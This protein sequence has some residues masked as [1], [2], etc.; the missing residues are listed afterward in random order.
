MTGVQTCALPISWKKGSV[1]ADT[2]Y[3]LTDEAGRRIPVQSF[4]SA[5]WP[6]GSVKWSRHSAKIERN[7][8][9]LFLCTTE[10]TEIEQSLAKELPDQFVIEG[11]RVHACVP[12]TGSLILKDLCTDGRVTAESGRLTLLL[13][14]REEE[15]GCVVTKQVPYLGV[16]KEA[17]LEE[18][19]SEKA[20]IC[21]HGVHRAEQGE[22]KNIREIL[23]FVLRLTFY[24]ESENIHITHTFLYDG[25]EQRDFLKGLGI[26]FQ[27]PL[28]GEVYN[29]HV[30][31]ASEYG[32]FHESMK[33]LLAWRPRIPLDLYERQMAG[34]NLDLDQMEEQLAKDIRQAFDNMPTWSN[35]HICQDSA[36]HYAIR[37]RTGYEKCCYLDCQHG[38]RAA[39]CAAVAGEDGGIA[40][41]LRDFWQKYP[42]GIWM[43][44]IDTEC[45]E[46]TVWLWTP[47]AEAMDYRHYDVTGYS[48]S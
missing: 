37:K 29:H 1:K 32:C 22:G 26:R 42:S 40:V 31:I 19:G 23:P 20:V 11:K 45:A 14:E 17:A 18:N 15:A 34:Q 12:K 6:D 9:D 30:K 43:D 46:V 24:K 25:D 47:D 16:I 13:E 4:V 5:Y 36:E 28:K 44:R 3:I 7:T 41:A 10:K 48:Q 38:G 39:G 21:L 2:E 8:A 35:Y 27:C 33:L